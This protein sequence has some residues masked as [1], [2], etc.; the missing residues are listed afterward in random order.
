MGHAKNHTDRDELAHESE[1]V[2]SGDKQHQAEE[3][4]P[5]LQVFNILESR[6]AFVLV[7][8]EVRPARKTDAGNKAVHRRKNGLI[9][10]LNWNRTAAST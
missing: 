4:K 3:R 2:A 6:N 1:H 9:D 7:V 5:N 8:D 10:T